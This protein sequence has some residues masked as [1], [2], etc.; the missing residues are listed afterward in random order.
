[1]TRIATLVL[2]VAVVAAACGDGD[3]SAGVD[4]GSDG[5]SATSAPALPAGGSDDEQTR[6][7]DG[8]D[9]YAV[10]DL[11]I[12]VTHPEEGTVTYRLSCL[13]DTASIDDTGPDVS[14][15]AACRQLTDIDAVA[16]V[17]DGPDPDR[18]CTEIY[19]GPDEAH[20]TGTLDGQPVDLV[21][22]RADGCG[23]DDWD[24]TLGDVL[25]APAGTD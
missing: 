9:T 18:I 2:L 13:G 15:E 24:R 16:L 5:S 25:P 12:E 14:A 19:G 11:T 17:V 8:D 3:D 4:T 7:A 22:D 10:A 1:M 23:I 6:P 20:I 21:V